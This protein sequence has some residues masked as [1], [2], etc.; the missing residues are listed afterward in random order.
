MNRCTLIHQ[1]KFLMSLKF[2]SL[3]LFNSIKVKDS[4]GLRFFSIAF[5]KTCPR[6]K[7]NS[8]IFLR[9]GETGTTD[10]HKN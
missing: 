5:G 8:P 4:H 1:L 7:T 6:R 3:K 10:Q 9:N 2:F